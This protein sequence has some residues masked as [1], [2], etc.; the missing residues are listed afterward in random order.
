MSVVEGKGRRGLAEDRG[1]HLFRRILLLLSV[2]LS[3]PEGPSTQ[4]STTLAPNTIP[5]MAFGTNAL[6]CW[7]LGISGTVSIAAT[8]YGYEKPREP[9]IA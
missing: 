4:N 8:F 7:V 1:Y 5:L 9:N 3:F 6:N 2:L